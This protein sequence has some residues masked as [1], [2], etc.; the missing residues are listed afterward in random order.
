MKKAVIL[1]FLMALSTQLCSQSSDTVFIRRNHGWDD[2][3]IKYKTD[4]I[5]FDSHFKSKILYGTMVLPDTYNQ[6]YALGFGLSLDSVSIEDCKQGVESVKDDRVLNISEDQGKMA[7]ETELYGNCCHSYFCDVQILKDETVNLITYGYGTYCA[8]I[9][10]Y[11][12]T[13][14]FSWLDHAPRKKI[15]SIIMNND[16]ATKYYLR[17]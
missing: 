17:E 9:C 4:T 5:V 14:Y 6:I 7:V 2:D 8:C 16:P 10:S 15:K 3:I 11:K 13:F 12:L 1:F